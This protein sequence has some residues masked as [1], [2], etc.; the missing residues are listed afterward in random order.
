MKASD[1]FVRCLEEEQ[2]EYVFGVP[3]EENAEFLLSLDESKKIRFINTRHEQSAAFM[4]D[5]YGRL[6]GNPAIALGTL[7]P[8]ATNLVT[9]VANANMDRS[10][11]IVLTGQGDIQSQH[12]ESHQIIDV[13]SMYRP[14]TKWATSIHHEDNIP[15][16][17]RKAVRVC[18][19]EK[20]GA[21][22]VELPEDIAGQEASGEPLTPRRFRRPRPDDT[23]IGQAFELLRSARRPVIIAGNGTIRRRASS[24]LRRFCERTGIGVIS[25]FMAKGCVDMDADYCLF[26]I[27]LQQ[28][29]Q[30]S[31]LVA[32]SD[33]IITVGYDMAEYP[34][35]LWDG[36]RRKPNIHIDFMPAE[37]DAHYHPD[38]E[39][40]GDI[41]HAL[42]LLTER[43]DREGVPVF[44][45]G[46][47]QETRQVLLADFAEHKDDAT[48]GTIRPQKALWDVRQALGPN[49]IVLCGVGAHKMWVGRYYHCHE[50]NT[51][52]I[53][54]GFCAMGMPLPGSIAAYLVHPDRNIFVVTGDGDFLMNVHEMETAKRLG[55]K[56]TAMVW[57]DHDYGLITWK[58]QTEFGRHI[59]MTFG[60][61]NWTQLAESFGWQCEVVHRS[62][63]LRAAIDRGLAHPGP[64]LL[65]V[66]IDYR[67]NLLLTERLGKITGR[68]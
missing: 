18:R 10:P 52:L 1:L 54:N 9:G 45:L 57:E 44:D 67:E 63:D 38:V 58:Q 41:A 65:V 34:P 6:T 42:E 46:R 2:I 51:C 7:G 12:K 22:L 4:A 50:P 40:I 3:G 25:T 56:I 48:D 36:G 20:P 8:G 43:V 11:M 14:I 59:D 5:V 47:Q 66:P 23:A 15:E 17:V 30:L 31:Y 33:L 68:M 26:T 28:R 49:D 62:R 24:E 13:V 55:A 61:P 16:V 29:D 60:N 27:G 64:S 37:I 39:L 53:S 35:R 32:E 21:V 19:T